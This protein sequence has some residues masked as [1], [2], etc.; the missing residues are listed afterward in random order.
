[1]TRTTR[2]DTCPTVVA[3]VILSSSNCAAT[4][5][6]QRFQPTAT[7]H[8]MAA[9]N[10]PDVED[11]NPS[12]HTVLLGEGIPTKEE[13]LV[14]Y[15]AKFTWRQLKTFVN[16][17]YFQ[18]LYKSLVFIA[19]ASS[20]LAGIS[21][22]SDVTRNSSSDM[23]VGLKGSRPSMEATVVDPWHYS[24]CLSSSTENYLIRYRL[25]WG[26]PDTLTKLPSHLFSPAVPAEKGGIGPANGPVLASGLP[27][28]PPDTKPYFT[29]DIPSQLVSIIMNDWP[30]SGRCT[31]LCL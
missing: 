10:A 12:S 23:N 20:P 18:M 6:R 30:Y 24:I 14:Y 17:G 9:S 16:S 15:P 28:I 19:E 25:R 5:L 22:C 8:S 4:W 21:G 11:S 2:E 7:Q 31:R 29:A 27:P 3:L 26:K 1:M 13:L